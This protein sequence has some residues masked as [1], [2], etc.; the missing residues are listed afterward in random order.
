MDR[1]QNQL[2]LFQMEPE[3]AGPY[4]FTLGGKEIKLNL[5]GGVCSS[6][7]LTRTEPVRYRRNLIQWLWCIMFIG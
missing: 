2:G 1:I 7:H 5:T 3:R 4:R 6:D